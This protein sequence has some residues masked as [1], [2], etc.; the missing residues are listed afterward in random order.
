MITL[1]PT[2][3]ADG[4][5]A[6]QHSDPALGTAS[7]ETSIVADTTHRPHAFSSTPTPPSDAVTALW[8]QISTIVGPSQ[9][10]H[11]STAPQIGWRR[12]ETEAEIDVPTGGDSEP[13]SHRIAMS[14][15]DLVPRF[16]HP[17]ALTVHTAEGVAQSWPADAADN[18]SSP[19]STRNSPVIAVTPVLRGRFNN[20]S[21]PPAAGPVFTLPPRREHRGNRR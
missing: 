1:K 18:A 3:T 4:A 5:T 17:V 2:A 20:H 21:R 8:K 11:G 9:Q 15:A 16:G 6:L 19:E 12:A 14:V 13:E 10:A 7:W